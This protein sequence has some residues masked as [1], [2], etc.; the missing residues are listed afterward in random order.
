MIPKFQMV[1]KNG[2]EFHGTI[3]KI[4]KK[5]TKSKQWTFPWLRSSASALKGSTSAEMLK[6]A[7]V[8]PQVN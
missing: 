7:L 3:R 6:M 8:H 5:K 2:D 1:V 4:T